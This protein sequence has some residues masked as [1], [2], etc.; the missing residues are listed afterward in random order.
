MDYTKKQ[1][2]VYLLIAFGG[3]W[4]LQIAA[5]LFAPS[6]FALALPVSAFAPLVGV[7]VAAGGLKTSQ[8]GVLWRLETRGRFRYFVLAWFGPIVLTALGA[9]VYFL[10][11]PGDLDLSFSAA[12]NN[13]I[14][15]GGTVTDGTI[16]GVPISYA[17]FINCAQAIT[18]PP[19][20]NGLFGLGEEVGWRGYLAPALA[21]RFGKRIGWLLSGALWGIW[22]APA[23]IFNGY[24]YGTGYWGAPIT[25]VFLLCLFS[26]AQGVILSWLYEKSDCILVPSLFSGALSAATTLPILFADAR[27]STYLLGPVPSGLLGAVPIFLFAGAILLFDCEPAQAEEDY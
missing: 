15:N 23:V 27:V 13:V 16:D 11:L 26:A 10:V 24:Q 5:A 2:T 1:L 19:L 6:L 3:G 21:D 18:Y 8:C 17:V 7:A 14:Q 9:A 4:I 12:I 20:L 25:G 22:Y